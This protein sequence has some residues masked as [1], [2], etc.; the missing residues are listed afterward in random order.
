M[1]GNLEGQAWRYKA[2]AIFFAAMGVMIV[3]QVIRLQLFSHAKTFL[4]HGDR[5]AGYYRTIVPTRGVIYDRWG[6]IL[7]GNTLV[8]EIGVELRDVR[9]PDTIAR[10]LSNVLG[11]EYGRLYEAASRPYS[12]DPANPAVYIPLA[13]GATE[14]QKIQIEQIAADLASYSGNRRDKNVTPPSMA[15]LVYRPY[16][17][18]SY[19]ENE[20]ASNLIGFVNAEGNGFGLERKFNELLSGTPATVWVPL[21]PNRVTELPDIPEGTS[22]V[23]TLDR[24]IQAAMEKVADDAIVSTG[25]ESATIVVMDPTNGEILAMATTPR[26]NLNRFWEFDQIFSGSTPFNRA[27][28]QPYEPGSVFK[29]FTFAAAL[30]SQTIEP[31][32]VFV[33]TGVIEVGGIYIRNWNGGA[34]GPQTMQGCM[35]HSLNVCL[36]WMATQLGT[37]QFYSYMD[38]FGFGRLTGVELAGEDPGRLKMPGDQDWFMS[39]LGTNS[40]GQGI[41]VTPVQMLMG[42]SAIANEGRMVAPHIVRSMINNGRQYNTPIQVVGT[43]ISADTARLATEILSDSLEKESSTALVEGYRLAGK[44]GTAQIPTPFGYSSHLTNAS[45]VGWG[46]VDDPRFIVYIWL[47]KPTSDIWASIVAAPIF[48]EAVQRLVVLMELPPDHV[49]FQMRAAR[50]Q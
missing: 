21:D 50:S 27:I 14:E 36:A 12:T 32:T 28:S 48:S 1:K 22:L 39:D 16:L 19:P 44:T 5:N 41:A 2:I 37:N 43:P 35:Q 23:L 6:K 26:M 18:R 7:A 30:D 24:E 17:Q 13:K 25:S 9:N 15:G 42:V 20:V 8:Y 40:F 47:E 3:G 34:W 4:E 31:E 38:A 45:F 10:T 49:R 29:V 46:P 33:D 11:Y